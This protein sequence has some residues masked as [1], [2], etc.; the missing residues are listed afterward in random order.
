MAASNSFTAELG[1]PVDLVAD[2]PEDVMGVWM[3]GDLTS[4][5]KILDELQKKDLPDEIMEYLEEL[6]ETLDPSS[7][8][9]FGVDLDQPLVGAV[10]SEPRG[11][12]IITHGV[13]DT[14]VMS[15]KIDDI[16]HV[17][18]F[19]G[20]AERREFNGHDGFVFGKG[21]KTHALVLRGD[22]ALW[23][24]GMAKTSPHSDQEGAVEK[25]TAALED[26][27][28]ETHTSLA[29]NEDFVDTVDGLEDSSMLGWLNVTKITKEEQGNEFISSLLSLLSP[30]R[31][32]SISTTEEDDV[33]HSR[34]R[35]LFTDDEAGPAAWPTGLKRDTNVLSPVPGLVVGGLHMIVDMDGVTK[36]IK[37]FQD[38]IAFDEVSDAFEEL[39]GMSLKRAMRPLSGELGVVVHELPSLKR[40]TDIG[41]IA[42]I[43]VG[44]QDE[45]ERLLKKIEGALEDLGM[46]VDRDKVEDTTV[47]RVKAGP[48]EAAAASY[49][50]H[51]WLTTAPDML[52]DIIEGKVRKSF[53]EDPRGARVSEALD[54]NSPL[55]FFIDIHTL[56]DEARGLIRKRDRKEFSQWKEMLL[57]A[58][59]LSITVHRDGSVVDMVTTSLMDGESDVWMRRAMGPILATLGNPLS[60]VGFLPAFIK[61]RRRAKTTE[62]TAAEVKA[63]RAVVAKGVANSHVAYT[64][65][66]QLRELQLRDL[67]AGIASS[68]IGAYLAVLGDF[69]NRMLELEAEIYGNFPG[70]VDDEGLQQQRRDYVKDKTDYL[71]EFTDSL[72]RRIE[73]LHGKSAWK[74]RPRADFIASTKEI[75]IDC[76]SRAV[77]HC[78]HK[79]TY[80]PFK[81]LVT[82]MSESSHFGI[83]ADL[84]ILSDSR[85]TGLANAYDAKWSNIT[86][87]SEQH[88]LMNKVREGKIVRD[89]VP[90]GGTDAYYFV[91]AAP[92]F[93]GDAYRGAVMVGVQI[94]DGLV[95]HESIAIGWDVSYIKGKS[96]I[97]SRLSEEHRA[98]VLNNLPGQSVKQSRRAQKTKSLE[99]QFVPLAGNYYSNHELWA[100]ISGDYTKALL[101]RGH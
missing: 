10:L 57:I 46:D 47:Y 6:D 71:N 85:G 79:L 14:K 53:R 89:V 25:V 43:G 61:Y 67:A 56:L 88:A 83:R 13:S 54:S 55:V 58:E 9:G 73:A 101:V 8:L 12:M 30:L 95:Q 96:L 60:V 32:C 23:M 16:L 49:G 34:F 81:N 50:G 62:A 45:A 68:E 35:A 63:A 7:W 15:K 65:T 33:S 42:F 86:S 75:L 98:E 44:E 90:F 76:S 91:S 5:L 39:M 93:N 66:R 11:A 72:S 19:E 84:A 52:D 99:I 51:I 82:E 70:S 74:D 31:G 21:R 40:E 80:Q 77:A 97:R 22:R 48:I 78:F 4:R 28:K 64:A 2:F 29:H 59:G 92:I 20:D 38:S 94:D 69:R 27:L 3:I 36:D 18:Q 1:D 37:A 24:L 87:Y 41:A 26:L 100:V 17:L